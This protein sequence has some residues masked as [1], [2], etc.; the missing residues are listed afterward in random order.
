MPDLLHPVLLGLLVTAIGVIAHR[1]SRAAAKHAE[2]VHADNDDTA[3]KEALDEGTVGKDAVGK[4]APGQHAV[5]K[6]AAKEGAH[7][8]RGTAEDADGQHAEEW[9]AD[10]ERGDAFAELPLR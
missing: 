9:H 2:R 6:D 10:E 7:G 4:D 8:K 1:G 3:G 5:G